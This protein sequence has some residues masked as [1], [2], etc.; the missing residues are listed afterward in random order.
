MS[1]IDACAPVAET[2]NDSDDDCD[3]MSDETFTTLGEACTVGMGACIAMGHLECNTAG[4]GVSCDVQPGAPTSETYCV[5]VDQLSSGTTAGTASLVFKR[6]G[7]DGVAVAA[8]GT[9]TG[10]TTGKANLSVAGCE[11]HSHQPDVAHFFPSC[12]GSNLVSANTCTGTAFDAILSVRSGTASAADVVCSDDVSGCG[13][14]LQ[15]KIVNANITGANL[16][17]IIVDGYGTTGNG[18]YTLTYSIQ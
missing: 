6:G 1:T 16:V 12:P 18:A 9:V 17:W 7:R 5:V 10:T 2:C 15:P 4:T 3:M 14:G 11:A 13:N 8:S